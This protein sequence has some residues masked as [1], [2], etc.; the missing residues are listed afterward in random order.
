MISALK[1]DRTV[2]LAGEEVNPF[3]PV[4]EEVY[5]DA[6]CI[7]VEWVDRV[8]I[9][10]LCTEVVNPEIREWDLSGLSREAIL[11]ILNRGKL[12]PG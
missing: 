9:V 1:R 8:R 6:S 5:T 2:A 3:L 4:T 10:L 12:P 11:R 7:T